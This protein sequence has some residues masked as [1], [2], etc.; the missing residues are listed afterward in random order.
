M[1]TGCESVVRTSTP[2]T[3]LVTGIWRGGK[4]GT[5]R[6]IRGGSAPYRVTVFGSKAVLDQKPGGDYTPML[7]E[8]IKFFQTGV[9][10][11][12]LEET[13]EIM[14]FMEA[15]DESK[16]QGGCAFRLDEVLKKN[17]W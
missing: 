4:V 7:R 1:G 13:I 14:A 17:G 9:A 16:R 3:D 2:D 12:P 10:P 8:V 11:V 5:V 6:G 15:A